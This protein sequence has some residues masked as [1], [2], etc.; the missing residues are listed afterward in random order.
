MRE[1]KVKD[2]GLSNWRMGFLFIEMEK[3]V[4]RARLE[5]LSEV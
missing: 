4:G 1:G 2:P 3:N 5:A